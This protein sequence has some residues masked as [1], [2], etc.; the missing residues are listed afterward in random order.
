MLSEDQAK[1]FELIAEEQ[2][3][4]EVAPLS[5]IVRQP[6]AMGLVA[7]DTQGRWII[8][9]KGDLLHRDMTRSSLH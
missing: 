2:P 5:A 9:P 8:T 3:L 7:C 1:V 6:M 4:A